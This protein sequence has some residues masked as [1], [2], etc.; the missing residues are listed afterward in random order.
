MKITNKIKVT[1]QCELK[2]PRCASVGIRRK[3]EQQKT[4]RGNASTTLTELPLAAIATQSC[5]Y[6][7]ADRC[8]HA[9]C[10]SRQLLTLLQT[11]A[12]CREDGV[13]LVSSTAHVQQ[14][15]GPFKVCPLN[16]SL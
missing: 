5:V 10:I 16:T 13:S 6:V 12:D 14:Q 1:V 2:D 7:Q 4:A 11:A 3:K 8:G 15:A 9:H